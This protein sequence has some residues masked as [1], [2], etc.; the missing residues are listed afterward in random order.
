MFALDAEAG[1]LELEGGRGWANAE[2][3]GPRIPLISPEL[4]AI[5]RT[6]RG[7]VVS[8]SGGRELLPDGFLAASGA[9]DGLS[10]PIGDPFRP[11]GALVAFSKSR[12]SF[13]RQEIEFMQ[14][15]SHVLSAAW[16]RERSRALEMRFQRLSRI[17]AMGQLTGGI[18]HDFN[19][20]LAVILNHASFTRD[21][22]DTREAEG[23]AG[24]SLDEIET[25]ATRAA[26]LTHQL[27]VFS[28]QDVVDVQ[29]VDVAAA[30]ASA[31]RMLARTVGEGVEVETELEPGLRP[32][33]AGPGQIEQI[34]VN[35]VVNARDAMPGGGRV[36]IAVD[37]AGRSDAGYRWIRITVSDDGIGM[38]T[39]VIE[40]A[41]EPFFTTKPVGEGSGLGLATV[42]G[43]VSGLGG[44][45]ELASE[46]GEGTHVDILLPVAEEEREPGSARTGAPRPAASRSCPDPA[47]PSRRQV[48]L[49]EDDPMVRR[50]TA[51]VLSEGGYDVVVAEDAP[52]ALA[53]VRQPGSGVE[54]LLTDVVMPGMS[55][56]ELAEAIREMVPGICVVFM[57]GYTGDSISRE[58]VR[59]FEAGF[60][61]KPFTP[62]TLLTGVAAAF[63]R[64]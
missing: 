45:I 24:Q 27:L 6:G 3:E 64:I 39:E 53:L 7:A 1:A 31:E 51:R 20:L 19:N 52:A 30:V 17:E 22:L 2:G 16:E 13:S 5:L 42:Y 15:T 8:D 34:V 35:L 61:E 21:N 48:L 40:K 41:F 14:A 33:E 54:V 47:P 58:A 60:V 28:R 57:S 63:D 25:A 46:P 55:G 12:R 43:I 29:A 62:E 4:V 10:V 18:A 26:E 44:S 59:D 11:S 56:V 38:R 32:I 49:V 9:C 23:A 37:R 50:L 36:R